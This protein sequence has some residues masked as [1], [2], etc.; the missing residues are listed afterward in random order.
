[1][2]GRADAVV[3]FGVTGDLA[4]KKLIPALYELTRR[5]R[6]D[7][8]VV[9][10]ART[11][12]DHEQ[13]VT[14]ARKAV[15]E[16][17]DVVDEAA[18]D[19][20]AG[21]LTMVSGEYGTPETYRRLASELG[22]AVRPLFYLAIP[23]TVFTDVVGGLAGSGLAARGRV[24][25]E[26]PFGHDLASAHAL[27]VTLRGAFDPARTFRIDHYLGKEAV[28][29]IRAVRFGN[30]LLEPIW[31]REHIDNVQITLAEEF[32]TQ[33]RAG[34]YDR[35]GAVRDVLQNHVL[36]VAALLA[37][38]PGGRDEE[39]HVLRR[40]R[41]LTPAGTVFGQYAG[42][43]DEPGVAPGSATETF[44]AATLR[45]DTRRWAG[46]P[47]HL[48][49]GKHLATT[50]TEV[51]VTLRP[52]SSGLP[53]A[54]PN[55][56]RLRLGRGDGLGLTLNV[57]EPGG[58]L[59]ARPLPLDVDFGTALGRRREAYERLIDDA[60]DGRPDRFAS[61][62]AIREEWRI[63]TPVLD[64]SVPVHPYER[65]GWG[66]TTVGTLPAGGWHPVGSAL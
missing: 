52:A 6:L 53:G 56:L 8:P 39:L 59:A 57:K 30:R 48:R 33:G 41:P 4:A 10:V 36:Q 64:G 42:Y 11:T 31:S 29:G 28:E 19:A 47:F 5:G 61:E 15:T 51:V 12:W 1:M 32:G 45:I 16:A 18:F 21:R 65:G 27:A 37:A 25:V 54:A 44:V 26:K 13:L 2:D 14:A 38:E 50:A 66:P 40:M 23:P 60:M 20:L 55:L 9:G 63:V 34:F 7:V 17:V 3:L 35:S 24:I 62:E 46:V 43:R 49:A 58:T 22:A